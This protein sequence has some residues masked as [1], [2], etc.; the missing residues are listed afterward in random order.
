[1]TASE[2]RAPARVRAG[3]IAVFS[4]PILI[5]ILILIVIVIVIVIRVGGSRD[6]D[7]E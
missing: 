1:M 5:L 4:E 6:Q 2:G 7:Y 3:S